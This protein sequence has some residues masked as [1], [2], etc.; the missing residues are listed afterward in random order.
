MSDSAQTKACEIGNA[1]ITFLYLTRLGLPGGVPYFFGA[2]LPRESD[3]SQS[4]K[5]VPREDSRLPDS[6]LFLLSL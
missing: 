4:S 5:L 3:Y 2:S 6:F 1:S